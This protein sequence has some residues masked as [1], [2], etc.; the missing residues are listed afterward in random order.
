MTDNLAVTAATALVLT[1]ALLFGY[2]LEPGFDIESLGRRKKDAILYRPGLDPVVRFRRDLWQRPLKK[3]WPAITAM[4]VITLGAPPLMNLLGIPEV[5]Y[6]LTAGTIP[7][8]AIFLLMFPLGIHLFNGDR[9][10]AGSGCSRGTFKQAWAH[11]P[12]PPYRVLRGIWRHGMVGGLI[13]WALYLTHFVLMMV[14]SGDWSNLVWFHASLLLAI[15]A[16]AGFLVAGAA[17]DGFRLTLAI[18]ALIAI[19]AADIGFTIGL[20]S[21]GITMTQN[22][23]IFVLFATALA[24]ALIGGLPPLIHL[25]RSS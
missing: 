14:F 22:Q 19:P 8:L 23:Q 24:A 1:A 20:K 9:G 11:L 4:V 15:P 25:R 16:G 21:A 7:G 6:S 12:L 5:F 10:I 13:C 3:F 18:A 2:R 17:G